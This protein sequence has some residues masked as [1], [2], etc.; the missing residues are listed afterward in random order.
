MIPAQTENAARVTMLQGT[1]P[2]LPTSPRTDR[3]ANAI[4]NALT[5][6]MAHEV[7]RWRSALI[8]ERALFVRRRAPK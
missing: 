5:P 4:R 8:E 3:G 1:P 6:R 7:L 2:Y